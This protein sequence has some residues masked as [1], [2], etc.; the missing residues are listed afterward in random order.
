MIAASGSCIGKTEKTRKVLIAALTYF[1]SSDMKNKLKLGL[2]C[3]AV[4]VVAIVLFSF[5]FER[6]PL[7]NP[8]DV[9]NKIRDSDERNY[10]LGIVE[11]DTSFCDKINAVG[12]KES[13]KFGAIISKDNVSLCNTF[14]EEDRN[15][16]IAIINEDASLCEG[17]EEYDRN[18][19]YL[20]V[21]HAKK[22]PSLCNKITYESMK[23][24]CLY[25]TAIMTKN[26]SL[27]ENMDEFLKYPCLAA[28][29][30]DIS[31]CDNMKNSKDLC[32]LGIAE[33]KKDAYI[34]NKIKSR[35]LIDRDTCY[36]SV[37]QKMANAPVP[38]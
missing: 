32:Y 22:D 25:D 37:A 28:V 35:Y 19:C 24:I 1:T 29:K 11:A 36:F 6:K 3:I 20:P 8:V 23:E 33:V 16:C 34:C 31:I 27:C 15:T 14:G 26:S 10:C 7:D 38:V 30:G 17:M 12:L 13:C 18:N 9:C 21:A 2:I 5:S 4:A